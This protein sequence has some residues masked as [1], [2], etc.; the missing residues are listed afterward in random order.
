MIKGHRQLI[1]TEFQGWSAWLL[2]QGPLKLHIVPQVGGRLMGI[3]VDDVQLAYINPA[4]AGKVPDFAPA[5]WAALCVDWDFPLWGGGKTWIAPETRWPQG[6]PHKEL[7][8]G[9]WQVTQTWLDDTSMGIEM[10]SPIDSIS[11]L[12]LTRRI[13]LPAGGST[14][15]IDHAMVNM[16]EQTL[17][18]GLWDVL[19]I[20]RAATVSVPRPAS[21][22]H[23]REG[24]H[25]MPDKGPVADLWAHG[26]LLPAD[27]RTEVV[28]DEALQ[29]KVGFDSD[30]GEIWADISLPEG[31]FCYQRNSVIPAH[32][33]WAHGH[34]L[35]VFNAAHA[36]Y[37]E[38]E[39]HAP[40]A[41][42]NPGERADYTIEEAAWAI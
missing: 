41:H 24:I 3:S 21:S 14:W 38:I 11:G 19:M 12:Q 1:Q 9:D 20:L 18:C 10:Q 4:L 26:V 7:D 39:T 8:S 36:P 16:G 27:R 13:T 2:E 29:F 33:S 17:H 32:A 37:L 22:K 35:E 28:C 40:L 30:N 42:L 31:N 23:E 34:P 15:R 6:K 5:R 25:L